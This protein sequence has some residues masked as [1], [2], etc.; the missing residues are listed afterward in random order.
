MNHWL[1]FWRLGLSVTFI[2][3]LGLSRTL[4]HWLKHGWLELLS[5]GAQPA[6]KTLTQQLQALLT[7]AETAAVELLQRTR[8]QTEELLQLL[9]ADKTEE[10]LQAMKTLVEVLLQFLKTPPP[11]NPG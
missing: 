3:W 9:K 11:P 7:L 5:K 10:L 6:W 8:I 2:H 1:G 4:R